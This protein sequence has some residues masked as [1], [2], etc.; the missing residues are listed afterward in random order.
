ML[1]KVVIQTLVL[2]VF[3]CNISFSFATGEEPPLPDNSIFRQ[4]I[5]LTNQEF[6]G[7]TA[8]AMGLEG[9]DTTI[10]V[11]ALHIFGPACGLSSQIPS[12][13]LQSSIKSVNL[14]DVFTGK[15]YGKVTQVLNIPD[16]KP[17]PL[18]SKDIAAYIADKRLKVTKLYVSD[19]LP[20]TGETVWLAAS[21][22]AGAPQWVKLHKA[23]VLSAA[24]SVIAIQYDNPNLN[25][26]GTSGAPILN[27]DGKVVGVNI[28]L[29]LRNGVPMGLINPST[30]FKP[31]IADAL[32]S[33]K[34]Y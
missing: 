32:I 15:P 33:Y 34:P 14:I 19:Q 1:K 9:K 25:L 31:M 6:S 16:A 8:W 26:I 11:T 4:T 30:S 17:N 7:G 23:T 10:I 27:K 29:R 2:I 12:E 5:Q 3:V 28:G 13:N 18:V 21:V 22:I 20:V 24:D